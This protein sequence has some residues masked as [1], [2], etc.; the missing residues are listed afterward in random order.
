M[1][2]NTEPGKNIKEQCMEDL[3]QHLLLLAGDKFILIERQ[4]LNEVLV[5]GKTFKE[6]SQSLGQNADRQEIIF[7]RA[8]EKLIHAI[9]EANGKL[10]GYEK[11]E[12][13]LNELKAAQDTLKE[14]MS[15]RNKLSPQQR[16]VLD[17]SIDAAKL[18]ARVKTICTHGGI[19]LVSDLVSLTRSEF[20]KL[21]NCGETSAEE[22]ENFLNK[23][24]LSWGMQV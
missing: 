18:S 11:I 14:K 2:N 3:L 4:V 22:V 21:R 13:E 17:M 7:S 16:K 24:G 12:R 23:N 6:V 15:L 1:K 8:F 5:R 20:R 19:R 9:D 10:R